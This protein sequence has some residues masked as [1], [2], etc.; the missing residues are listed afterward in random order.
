M[1]FL[2]RFFIFFFLTSLTHLSAEQ[3]SQ[4]TST[5]DTH[6]EGNVLDNWNTNSVEPQSF[7]E[8]FINMLVILGLLI[9]FMFL[10]SWALKKMMKSKVS[11]IN[12]GNLIKLLETRYLST[13]VTIHLLEIDGKKYI[14]AESPT[15][16]TS[17]D[18]NESKRI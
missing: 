5:Y 2:F 16:V 6:D 15:A 4:E 3:T 8:K 10:A 17:L 1:N 12:A 9:A 11:Q 7:Q 14:I 18:H 13:R